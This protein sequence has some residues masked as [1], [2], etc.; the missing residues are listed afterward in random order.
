VKEYAEKLLHFF[1]KSDNKSIIIIRKSMRARKMKCACVWC[2]CK[3]GGREAEIERN[4]LQAKK[5]FN[6]G[7]AKL[8][9]IP[10]PLHAYTHTHIHGCT[11]HIVLV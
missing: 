6:I 5:P 3:K 11:C 1:S 7:P 8:E 2:F 4:L 10:M 9:R